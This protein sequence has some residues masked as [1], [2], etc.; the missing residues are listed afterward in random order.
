MTCQ[1]QPRSM[2]YFLIH[3]C[4][5]NCEIEFVQCASRYLTRT[6]FNT[7]LNVK[8]KV[9]LTFKSPSKTSTR[10]M[11][12][13]IR[14]KQLWQLIVRRR[15]FLQTA[16]FCWMG[17]SPDTAISFCIQSASQCLVLATTLRH[18]VKNIHFNWIRGRR[19]E[20]RQKVKDVSP[21]STVPV[22]VLCAW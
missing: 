1:L 14:Y 19:S 13:H 11:H 17:V 8:T 20:D 15:P 5:W 9:Y 6:K 12:K 7:T 4:M 3:S 10:F 18:I 2:L 16:Y 21:L 22:R